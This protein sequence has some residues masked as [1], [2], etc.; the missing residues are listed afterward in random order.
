MLVCSVLQVATY[1]D[2]DLTFTNV[3]YVRMD[4]VVCQLI[5]TFP[6]LKINVVSFLEIAFASV[7]VY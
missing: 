4:K 1:V 2:R 3:K 5:V 7:S 6:L